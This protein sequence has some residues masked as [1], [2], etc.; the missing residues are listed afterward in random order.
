MA[1]SHEAQGQEEHDCSHH[2]GGHRASS[3]VMLY[4]SLGITVLFVLAE[5]IIGHIANSLALMSDA[6]HNFCDALSLGL[7]AYAIWIARK[8]ADA[9]KTFGYHRVAILSAL[10]NSVALAVISVSILIGAIA[11]IRHPEPINTPLMLGTA[12]IALVVNSAIVWALHGGAQHSLNVRATYIH[13]ATDVIASIVVLI[14]AAVIHATNLLILDPLASLA[15]AVIIFLSCWK[16]VREA[17][18][19]L[20]ESTPRGMDINEM[21]ASIKAVP[22]VNAVHDLHVWTVSDGLNYLSCHIEVSVTQTMN[23]CA[24]IVRDVNRMLSTDFQIAHSTIQVES[25]GACE[26]ATGGDPLY[27]GN[28]VPKELVAP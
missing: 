11:A 17:T 16:I 27:C 4:F 9:R 6:G 14:T 26:D 28:M 10:A 3:G 19:I 12:A 8:P 23:G 1:A 2:G 20:L 18:D 5:A 25:P 24:G 21:A 7:S 22:D 15:I 13:M